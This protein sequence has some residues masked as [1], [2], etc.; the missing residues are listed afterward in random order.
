MKRSQMVTQKDA[1]TN[2]RSFR[3]F[4]LMQQFA[5]H[6]VGARIAQARKEAS[7]M[8][9]EQLAELLNVSK[10]SVQDYEAGKTIPWRHFKEMGAI[11]RRPMEWFL[12]GDD[13]EEER[14]RTLAARL[15]ALVEE[16]EQGRRIVIQAL[17][18]IDTR[19]ARIEAALQLP[20]E[21]ETRD[22]SS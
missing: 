1:A 21:R 22:T 20:D 15:E 13:D 5:A 6:E 2:L 17:A 19:L 11:F 12:H 18:G 9:Q 16:A 7:G 4:L 3:T 10:R 8:T 14:D